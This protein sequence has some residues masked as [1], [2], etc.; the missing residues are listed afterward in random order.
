[1]SLKYPREF[2]IT[3]PA[4][5][6]SDDKSVESLGANDLSDACLLFQLPRFYGRLLDLTRI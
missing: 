4:K 2:I 6:Y 3:Q 1:M 5:L